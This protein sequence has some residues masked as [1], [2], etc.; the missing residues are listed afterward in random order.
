MGSVI[1]ELIRLVQVYVYL[2]SPWY[3][4]VHFYFSI[5]LFIYWPTI[6]DLK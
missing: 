3:I 4:T 2:R 5:D 6:S 1:I